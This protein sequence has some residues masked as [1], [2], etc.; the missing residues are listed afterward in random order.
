MQIRK[1]KCLPI[2]TLLAVLIIIGFVALFLCGCSPY[3]KAF[4]SKPPEPVM[5]A[6]SASNAVRMCI[7]REKDLDAPFDDVENIFVVPEELRL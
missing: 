2:K 4:P 1:L 3:S 5:R 7:E 6:T